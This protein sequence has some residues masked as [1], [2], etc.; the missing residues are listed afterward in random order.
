MARSRDIRRLT[1][2][3]TV[4][5]INSTPLGTVVSAATLKKHRDAAGLRIGDEKTVDLPRYAA[6]LVTELER[7]EAERSR[8]AERYVDAR[9]R[10]AE[11]N[12]AATKASQDIA[13]IPDVQDIPRREAAGESLRTFCETYFKATFYLPWSPDHLRVIQRLEEAIKEGGL[14]AFAMPRGSGKTSLARCAALWAVLY[15]LLDFVTLIAGSK[16]CAKKLHKPILTMFLEDPLLLAD[17]PEAVYPFR[18]L[19]NSSKRQKQQHVG[20][21]LT[22]LH[23]SDE[24]L[25]FPTV[26]GEYLPAKLREAGFT[27]SPS[28][29]SVIT[30]TSLD[31]NLRGLHHAKPDGTIIRPSLVLLDDPQTRESARSAEQ[32]RH[33]LSLLHGDVLGL[34]GPGQTLSALVTCTVMYEGD[35]ADTLLDPA[36]SPEWRSERTR[37]MHGWPE[38]DKAWDEYAKIRRSKGQ[39]AATAYYKRRRKRMDAGAKPAWP[40]RFDRKK[41]EISAIQHAVNLFLR[42]GPEQFASELQNQPQA[43]QLGDKV[44]TIDEV[45]AKA[46]KRRKGEVPPT[47]THLTAFVDI[48]DRILFWLVAAWGEDF[49]GHIVDYGTWPEQ[50]RSTFNAASPPHT[51]RRKYP[52]K[53][54]DGAIQAGLEEIV[55]SLLAREFKRGKMLMRIERLLIDM[56]HKSH[57]GG[58]VRRLVGNSAVV[59]AK[60]VGIRASR[61]PIREYARRPGEVLGHYW[62]QP[63]VIRTGQFPHV[64]TDVNYWKTF[65]TDGLAT[66]A[67]DRGCISIF[68]KPE[69]HRLL[70]E[71]L[72]RSE[73]SVEVTG[74]YGTVREWSPYPTKPDNHWFDCLVGCAA[75]ASMVGVKAAGEAAATPRRKRYTQDDFRRRS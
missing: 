40:E 67:G 68:G 75:A 2:A 31:A 42:Y 66:A 14:L 32:T 25:V 1:P 48:Q 13:P 19:E 41:G 69:Q 26:P 7:V 39:K 21:H 10:Q 46:N 36:K 22:Q 11:R 60:G 56:G 34:A 15:G 35:L 62:Y 72:A 38:D 61:K 16:D 5:L 52:G 63:N 64:L 57:I 44:L 71:H 20:G 47:A 17:F 74:P 30:T 43:E 49:T 6:W 53:G 54:V 33:R 58:E 29:G 55:E 18:R 9:R 4:R 45:C 23:W 70:A 65:V 73:R 27:A 51:L 28:A 8:S 3:A 50:R 24:E 12:R 59:L 37:L